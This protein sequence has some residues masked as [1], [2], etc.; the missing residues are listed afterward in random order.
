M[1]S[2]EQLSNAATELRATARSYTTVAAEMQGLVVGLSGIVF[3]L[4]S[5]WKGLGSQAFVTAQKQVARDGYRAIDAL[6]GSAATMNSLAGTIENNLGPIYTAQRI[7]LASTDATQIHNAETAAHTALA[8]ITSAAVSAGGTLTSE[9]S[10]R[11]SGGCSTGAEPLASGQVDGVTHWYTPGGRLVVPGGPPPGG[12]PPGSGG[13]T[14]GCNPGDL[15]NFLKGLATN[16][17]AT[18]KNSFSGIMWTTMAGFLSGAA[19]STYQGLKT[20]GTSPATLNQ[21]SS[22]VIGGLFGP[23]NFAIAKMV[24]NCVPAFQKIPDGAYYTITGSVLG[25]VVE[26]GFLNYYAISKILP[27]FGSSPSPAPSPSPQPSPQPSPSPTH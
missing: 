23:G 1:S 16:P 10:P 20:G 24:R 2:A 14:S 4:L 13:D 7:A 26:G 19:N 8:T 3:S 18:L 9:V 25:G 17:I 5:T 6:N 11:V 27:N 21:L 22:G 15:L 12:P